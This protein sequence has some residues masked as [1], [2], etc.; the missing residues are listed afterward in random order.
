MSL[1]NTVLGGQVRQKL[2]K[3]G[4]VGKNWKFLVKGIENKIK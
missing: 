4:S 3:K 2:N 1:R